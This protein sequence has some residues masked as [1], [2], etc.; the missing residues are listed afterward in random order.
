MKNKKL[1]VKSKV[2]SGGASYQHNGRKR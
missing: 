1:V 2:R